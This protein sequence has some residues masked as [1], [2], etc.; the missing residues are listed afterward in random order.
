MEVDD[1]GAGDGY[2]ETAPVTARKLEKAIA[3]KHAE[4]SVKEKQKMLLDT[5]K[6]A[7]VKELQGKK[8]EKKN[9]LADERKIVHELRDIYRNEVKKDAA[10]A[11]GGSKL[12]PGSGRGK[13]LRP[14]TFLASGTFGEGGVKRAFGQVEGD[15]SVRLPDGKRIKLETGG[16]KRSF[17]HVEPDDTVTLPDGKR[18]KLE[19]VNARGLKRPVG[20]D[21]EQPPQS[22]RAKPQKYPV[23][24][25][26]TSVK[27]S[28]PDSWVEEGKL[29]KKQKAAPRPWAIREK[30]PPPSAWRTSGRKRVKRDSDSDS[31]DDDDDDDDGK[32]DSDGG[33]TSD[34][35]QGGEYKKYLDDLY[36]REVKKRKK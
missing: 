21:F 19:A 5:L 26:P 23:P 14:S 22:K 27:R 4:K 1:A 28:A 32:N 16:V 6:V 25:I 17:G 3:K 20:Q 30:R 34:D 31:D 10:K 12:L 13:A 9:D 35:G 8:G 29:V 18:I 24:L 33:D 11:K 36:N 2:G 7:R 15:D